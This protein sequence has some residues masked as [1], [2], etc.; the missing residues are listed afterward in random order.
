MPGP[1][2]QNPHA[3]F[4]A[5]MV[6]DLPRHLI[7]DDAVWE[8]TNVFVK[9]SGALAKRGGTTLVAA[10]YACG[11]MGAYASR[12]TDALERIYFGPRVDAALGFSGVA[13]RMFSFVP[14]SSPSIE[15]TATS[16]VPAATTYC[17]VPFQYG[18]FLIHPQTFT[19]ATS[20]T[21]IGFCGAAASFATYTN[22]NNVPLVAG[23]NAVTINAGD[24]ANIV[25]GAWIAAMNSGSR[26]YYGR[27][28]A[29]SGTTMTV[30]PTPT[31][32]QTFPAGLCQWSAH[33][34]AVSVALTASGIPRS[35][36][37]GAAWQN[38]AL[39]G[40][41]NV[42]T[43]AFGAIE[44]RPD[45]VAW[46]VLPTESTSI[47][48]T[49]YYGAIQAVP[50]YGCTPYNF[51]DLP[52]LRRIIAIRPV[53][54]GA[55]AVFGTDGI[56]LIVGQLE[57]ITATAGG[58]GA[59]VQQISTSVG[60]LSDH[61]TVTT[62][63]GV[64]FAAKES[65]YLF[66]GSRLTDLMAGKLRRYWRDNHSG[67]TMHAAFV[68]DGQH[69]VITSGGAGGDRGL[70]FNIGTGAWTIMSHHNSVLAAAAEQA[71]DR[72]RVWG[73]YQTGPT[74]TSGRVFRLDPIVDPSSANTTDAPTTA[75]TATI[76]T[77]TYPEGDPHAL[78]RFRHTGVVAT[79]KGTGA[80]MT[81]SATPGLE[82]EEASSSLGTISASASGPQRERFDHQIIAPAIGYTLTASG[83]DEAELHEIKTWANQLDPR[84]QT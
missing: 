59:T 35:A 53:G 16:I 76:K 70:M 41:C 9:R 78:K 6:Q 49:S 24:A 69:V 44:S 54:Q 73:G 81:V 27:V 4:A 32:T 33:V 14:G 63:L 58:F 82:G 1:L 20:V 28:V 5:G 21:P 61:A 66:D 65:V 77:K 42:Q 64:V 67:Q 48:G 2:R 8:A 72:S 19:S 46:T 34:T 68:L 52:Y 74:D 75:V 79:V 45:R 23:E 11:V 71:G 29:V 40:N 57:T 37:C 31:I 13:G 55:C 43:G 18:N 15:A 51:V 26:C 47:G 62:P 30:E 83:A 22:A 36:A 80:T 84:R 60:A 17:G 39:Y 3:S 7:P 50:P 56:A 10:S 25:P 38:R 12:N